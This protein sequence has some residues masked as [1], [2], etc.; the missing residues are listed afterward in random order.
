MFWRL[1]IGVWTALFVILSV[2]VIPYLG[3][4]SHLENVGAVFANKFALAFAGFF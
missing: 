1:Q 4:R 2:A 3:T